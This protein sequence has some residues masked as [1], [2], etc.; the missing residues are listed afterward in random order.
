MNSNPMKH[1]FALLVI[2]I[3]T[4]GCASAPVLADAP[5]PGTLDIALTKGTVTVGE[6]LILKYR[7][8]NPEN[9]RVL[10]S[11]DND[12]PRWLTIRMNDASGH[13]VRGA[14][15][16][17]EAAPPL[18]SYVI[19]GVPV[20]PQGQHE[21]FLVLSPSFQPT[22]P[23][24][25]HLDLTAH[26]TY[27]WGMRNVQAGDSQSEQSYSLPLTVTA[28][29]PQRL[30]AVAEGLRQNVLGTNNR[31]QY[32]LANKAL[33]AMRDPACLPVW[34]K[35][36]ADAKLDPWK[37]VD[38]MSQLQ[39]VGSISACD[40]LAEMQPIAPERWSQTGTAPFEVLQGMWRPATP[41]V[42]Q[43]INQL[44]AEA[45][46]PAVTEHTKLTGEVN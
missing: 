28:R 7:V 42:K 36:A 8:F 14:L 17:S 43:H 19:T 33:F 35:L 5:Q 30:R 26:L 37:A 11:I 27:T 4:W 10:V 20:G 3:S 40:I 25:Y 23:G 21:D 46:V 2:C 32:R 9:Q 39:D 31:D 18:R 44:L 22:Q 29:D 15:T 34:R 1:L 13:P 45:G 6:P 41:E 16:G 38:V 24:R 12:L